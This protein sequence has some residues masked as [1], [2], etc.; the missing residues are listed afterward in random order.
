MTTYRPVNTHHP[1]RRHG[2]PIIHIAH[3]GPHANRRNMQTR[4]VITPVD[5]RSDR[6]PLAQRHTHP[7]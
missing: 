1:T 2:T 6:G 5:V 4:P 3:N 7:L